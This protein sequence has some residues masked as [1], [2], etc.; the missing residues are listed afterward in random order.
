MTSMSPSG[1]YSQRSML[2]YLQYV[3]IDVYLYLYTPQ[4]LWKWTL[5]VDTV[6]RY[7]WMRHLS[8]YIVTT[9][10]FF[11]VFSLAEKIEVMVKNGRSQCLSPEFHDFC[12]NSKFPILQPQRRMFRVTPN[13]N[14]FTSWVKNCWGN[15]GRQP[16]K[17]PLLTCGR[18]KNP[19]D[20]I[21]FWE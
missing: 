6:S 8:W 4:I 17:T 2:K 18:E 19:R 7:V 21:T 15:L 20:P 3:S 10:F 12:H 1:N 14:H 16:V 9:C 11:S 13:K 5:H